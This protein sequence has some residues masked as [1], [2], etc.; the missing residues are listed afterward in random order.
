[1]PKPLQKLTIQEK[2]ELS[3]TI[4]RLAKISKA[5]RRSEGLEA[6]VEQR[7]PANFYG[8]QVEEPDSMEQ[9][10]KVAEKFGLKDSFF[11]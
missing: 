7:G 11:D 8:R 4:E 9:A 2:E 6:K 3:A 1:M 5:P 10:A